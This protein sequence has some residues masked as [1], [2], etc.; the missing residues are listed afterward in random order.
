M[1]AL[2]TTTVVLLGLILVSLW[3]VLYQLVKQQGRL[4]LRQD[5]LESRLTGAVRAAPT[6]EVQPKGLPVGTP[7]PPFRLPD[8]T[9]KTVSLEDFQGKR[10]FL[11]HWSPKCGFCDLIAPD[12]AKLQADFQ[13]QNV[14][15]LLVSYG[16]AESNRELAE[17]H[18]L[19]CPILLLGKSQTLDAFRSLGTPVA[20]L[21]DEGG[22]VAEPLAVGAEQVPA[23][24]REVAT[25]GAKKKK[26][27]F[28]GK[29]DL[30]ESRIERDGLKAGT[31]APAFELPDVHGN[32]VSL[33]EYRGRRVL[34]VFTDANCGP[35]DQLAP[36]L[37][38]LHRQHRK[39]GLALVLVGRG[40]PE[41]NR[42]KAEAHGFKFPV[43]LQ[44]QWEIS[45][46]YG[47]FSTPVAF[48]IGEDGVIAR[49]VAKGTDEIMTLAQ[50]GLAAGKEERNG[51]AI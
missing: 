6:V 15:L 26:T 5:D 10:V 44:K 25:A 35:C 40:D 23:L 3:V 7:V 33:E 50:K 49:S 19:E 31:P 14:Q 51:Q 28:G 12:L 4:L 1:I 21:L 37:V 34:L 45:K 41:E 36:D 48:L 8:L 39:N 42:R 9:G 2:L 47:I 18:G 46:K 30:S 29:R 24:A 20:Y 43:V 32:T 11:V 16:D 13:K 38:R 17:E 22:R 27:P